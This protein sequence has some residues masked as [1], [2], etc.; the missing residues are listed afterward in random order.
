MS[1]EQKTIKQ[2]QEELDLLYKDSNNLR[3]TTHGKFIFR[4]K[5]L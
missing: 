4:N 1:K 3:T 2:L 5:N